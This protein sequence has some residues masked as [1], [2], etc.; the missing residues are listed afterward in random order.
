MAAEN[1]RHL[2]YGTHGPRLCVR[3]DFNGKIIKRTGRGCDQ[4]GRDLGI[5]S[6]CLQMGMSKQ[7]VDD[8]NIGATLQ[9]MGSKTMPKRMRCYVL[10]DSGTP[11]RS[12]AGTL[13]SAASYV[14]A[15]FLAR[16]QPQTR[17]RPFPIDP[18][19]LK[20]PRGKHCVTIP[21]ALAVLNMEQHPLAVD[22]ADLKAYHLSDAQAR[23]VGRRQCNTI[24]EAWNRCQETRNLF[25]VENGWK[26]L[27]LPSTDD[28]FECLLLAER[29]AAKRNAARRPPD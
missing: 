19:N 8:P 24:T 23:R 5:P 2:Q 1:I 26:L 11:P 6:G 25:T 13:K 9:Q 28:A 14:A 29:Y 21:A 20:Q 18:K 17:P 3:H 15:R 10:V 12:A 22:R 7:D 4:S 16:K 27:R